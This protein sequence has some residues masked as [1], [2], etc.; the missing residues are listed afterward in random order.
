MER[1]RVGLFNDSFPPY[2]DGVIQVVKNYAEALQQ[3]HCDVTVVTPDHPEADDHFPY[4]VLRYPSYSIGKRIGYRMGNP[5][6]PKAV[7]TL[8]DKQF[9]LLHVHAPFISS[10]IAARCNKGHRLPVVV[11]YHTKFEIDI[12]KRTKG[13]PF[14][15][16]VSTAFVRHNLKQADEIWTVSQGCGESLRNIGYE[17]EYR[18]M[19]NGTDFPYGRADEAAQ[20]ALRER[21]G[22]RGDEFLFLFVGR[23]MWYKGL[24]LILDTLQRLKQQ[25]MPFRAVM[26]GGGYDLPAI[27]AYSEQLGLDDRVQFTGPM[28]DRGAL[29]VYYSITDIFLFPS[30]YDTSGL[31][32]REAAACDCPSMLVRGSCPAEGISDG[33][34]GFL[35]QE[36]ADDCARVLMQACADRGRLAQIGAAAGKQLY[37]SW[38]AAVDRAYARYREILENW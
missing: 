37:L 11:T 3:K 35:V 31:V 5:F 1:L 22:L 27:R 14:A 4:D 20:N 7:R 33:V 34:N 6:S 25:G 18:V 32:V 24:R 30:T 36:D 10:T 12:A 15:K 2:I 13:I 8:R 16:T 29:R 28:Y 38:D 23:M 19:P 17:G 9:D 26:I 21:L